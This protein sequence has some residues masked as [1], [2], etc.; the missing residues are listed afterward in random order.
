MPDLAPHIWLLALLITLFAGFVK[1]AV[2]FAMP[3]II[4]SGLTSLLDPKLAVAGI[5]LPIVVSNLAQSFRTGTRAAAEALRVFWRYI[6]VV[7]AA[8]LIFAQFV[9]GMRPE[10]FY[11][12]LGIPVVILS[13][14]QLVGV[15]MTIPPGSRWWAEWL[16]GGLSGMIGGL[17]GT[18]G[19]PTV[20]Y[21]LA[22]DTPKAR[23]IV[24]QGVI[25]GIGSVAL[26]VGHLKSGILNGQTVWF[27]A[28][29]VIPAL[30]GMWTG[31]RV[32]EALDPV[33][34]RRLTLAV[35][36]V[37]GLNLIRKGFGG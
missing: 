3:L 17:A 30:A 29:L 37:A 20:L 7:C 1:G 27:S 9:P 4:V 14:I 35:L 31:F 26:L 12:V 11:L 23:Q 21:L 19:P 8:I 22:I 36:I 15:R 32:Q 5:I 25:Y 18:W 24:A 2:G 16:F 28:L 6:L 33:L 10:T 34:F 13:A